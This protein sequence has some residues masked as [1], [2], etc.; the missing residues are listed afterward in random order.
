MSLLSI[1]LGFMPQDKIQNENATGLSN[2]IV[3]SELDGQKEIVSIGLTEKTWIAYNK[4]TGGVYKLW[5]GKLGGIGVHRT[6]LG[7]DGSPAKPYQATSEA[8]LDRNVHRLI[9][10]SKEAPTRITYQGVEVTPDLVPTVRFR[11]ESNGEAVQIT[12]SPILSAVTSLNFMLRRTFKVDRTG[13]SVKSILFETGMPKSLDFLTY[14]ALDMK[15]IQFEP[16]DS[17]S[18][19]D[20]AASVRFER[21][22]SFHITWHGET[23]LIARFDRLKL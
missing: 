5:E 1:V 12:E 22:P 20:M 10:G 18:S 4:S 2:R 15:P 19:Q 13:V 3:H 21:K 6:A 23:T 16:V 17:L 7:I 14:S 9:A 8:N 11:L